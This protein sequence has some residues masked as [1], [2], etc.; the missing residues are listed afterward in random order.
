LLFNQI[1]DGMKTQRDSQRVEVGIEMK[2]S[3]SSVEEKF[4]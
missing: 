1:V 3:L 4:D 2:A